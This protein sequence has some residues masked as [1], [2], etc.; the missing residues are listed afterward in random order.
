MK[1]EVLFS[2]KITK[3]TFRMFSVTHA[4]SALRVMFLFVYQ[5]DALQVLFMAQ[6]HYV[7]QWNGTAVF[8]S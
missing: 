1:Y 7:V 2:L 6:P 5:T 8:I 4:L 3:S